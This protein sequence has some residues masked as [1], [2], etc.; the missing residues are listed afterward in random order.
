MEVKQPEAPELTE[1]Q[2]AELAR[3]DRRIRY[4]VAPHPR[5]AN[6]PPED[7]EFGTDTDRFY[8]KKAAE[9][10]ARKALMRLSQSMRDKMHLIGKLNPDIK[11]WTDAT[12]EDLK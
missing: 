12:L 4:L 6:V 1:E 2:K 3:M 9:K 10:R 5:S 8:I 11:E 7:L